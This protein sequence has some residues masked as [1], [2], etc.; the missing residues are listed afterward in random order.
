MSQRKAWIIGASS[1]IGADLARE[2]ASRN[3]AVTVSAR[4]EVAL[5]EVAGS[6]MSILP[7]DISSDESVKQAANAYLSSHGEF[8]YVIVMAGFWKQMS[9]IDFDLE[10]FKQHNNV[11]VVGLARVVEAVLPRMMLADKGTLVGVSSVAGY[12]GFPGSAGYGPS[13]A[14]QLNLLESLR[15]DLARTNVDVITVS[16]GF[17]ETPMTST[18]TFPMPF[19]IS[20]ATAAK[21]IADGLER[22]KAE[23]VFPLPMSLMMKLAKLMPSGLWPKIFKRK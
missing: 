4:N 9:A 12:R 16:P 19:I 20:S 18:N 2:L 14:A 1:G 7:C 10:I 6:T 23:I 5:R 8:D 21:Y 17:V 15:A 3:V 22:N 11:N 13:K